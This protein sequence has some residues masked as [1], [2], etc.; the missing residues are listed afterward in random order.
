MSKIYIIHNEEVSVAAPTMKAAK[1]RRMELGL[2]RQAEIKTVD[3]LNLPKR[4]L[5]CALYNRDGF[6][7]KRKRGATQG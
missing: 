4:E 1:E 3:L 6:E 2:S 7:K 5:M